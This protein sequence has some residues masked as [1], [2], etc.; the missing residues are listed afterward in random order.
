[1]IL[2]AGL[3]AVAAQF[4]IRLPW[5]PTPITGQTFAVLL[6]GTLLGASRGAGAMLV[7]L[8]EGASGLPVFAGGGAG[9][10]H[11]LG[12]TGGYLIGFVFAAA[13]AGALAERGWDRRVTLTILSMSIATAVIFLCG[14]AWLAFFVGI[15]QVWTMGVGPFL[16]GAALKIGLATALLPTGW[17]LLSLVK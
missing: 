17:K 7:Y 12:P 2:G 16:P 6:V 13:V 5:T 3:V 9:V 11:L 8:L 14:A 1:M 4:V 10:A 15:D